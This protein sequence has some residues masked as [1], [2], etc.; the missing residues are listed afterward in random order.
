MPERAPDWFRSPEARFRTAA[1]WFWHRVPGHAEIDAA[2]AD[3]ARAG[4]GSVLV[5]GRLALD[6]ADWMS[7]PWR[8]A[9]AHACRRARAHGLGVEIYDEYNWISG[10]GGGRTVAGAEHLRERL[11]FWCSALAGG[12][13]AVEGIRFPFLDFLGPAGQDWLCEAGGPAWDEWE[14]VRAVAHPAAPGSPAQIRDVTARARLASTGPQGAEVTVC[15]AAGALAGQQVTVFLAARGAR[16]R[17]INYAMPEA[18]ERFAEEVCAPML[19]AAGGRAEAS[20]FDHPHAGFYTWEGQAG[21]AGNALLWDARLGH[22]LEALAPLGT[23]LLAL[24]GAAGP[25]TRRLRARAWEIYGTRLH[26][27]FFGTLSRWWAARGVAFSGHELLCHVGGY[28]LRDGLGGFD[29]RTM[30]GLDHFGIDAFRDTTT[31]DAADYAPQLSARMGDSVAR[32]SGRAR[33]SVEQYSTGRMTGI[34]GGAGHWGLTA[35]DLRAQML[36]HLLSGARRVVLHALWLDAGRADDPTPF[37][38]PRF[39]FPPGFNLQPWWEDAPDLL[40]E[41][42]RVSAFL[43]E[44]RPERPVALLYPLWTLRAAGAAEPA[45]CAAFGRW[46]EALDRAGAGWQVIDHRALAAAHVEGDTLV[47]PA[48][49]FRA[50]VLPGVEMLAGPQE[51]ALI[52]RFRAAGGVVTGSGPLPAGMLDPAPADLSAPDPAFPPAPDVA[53]PLA[54]GDVARPA[55]DVAAPSAPGDVARPAPGDAAPAPPG[56]GSPTPPEDMAPTIPGDAAPTV[57]GSVASPARCDEAPCTPGDAAPLAPGDALSPERG[58]AIPPVSGDAAT[59]LAGDAPAPAAAGRSV[60]DPESMATLSVVRPVSSR[61]TTPAAASIDRSTAAPGGP[62]APTPGG[63]S[64]PA[65]ADRPVPAPTGVPETATRE[66]PAPPM[67]D[68]QAPEALLRACRAAIARMDGPRDIAARAQDLAALARL[69]PGALA[70]C[71][72]RD[73]EGWKLALFNDSGSARDVQVAL[74]AGRWVLRAWTAR[75][76][77]VGPS[78]R[79]SGR[80]DL[81]LPPQACVCLRLD[82]DGM[83]GAE[84]AADGPPTAPGRSRILETRVLDAGWTLALAGAQAFH[85]VSVREGWER[86][87]WPD[88]SGT[89]LYRLWLDLPAPGPGRRW[90]LS[91]PG[92]RHSGTARFAGQDLG[93][94]IAG[95]ARFPLPPGRG[96]LELAL[97]NTGANRFYAGAPWQPEGPEASGLCQPPLLELH[98]I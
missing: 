31:V 40:A 63:T 90:E 10:H 77:G 47:T 22:A 66:M 20:F 81:H 93:R 61:T 88:V 76:G 83:P 56:D 2:L 7:A 75:D 71:V 89:G 70:N 48:G 35:E 84:Q 82:P 79:V 95:D 72:L 44:G 58:D 14:I 98:A 73:G 94:H 27:A 23:V 74:P 11:L 29:P 24:T 42:A 17:L 30:P 34:P 39:D 80:L 43:E 32:A 19:A 12:R 16:S 28:G 69:H 87:G 18:A 3:M 62:A 54:P 5:Q 4:I 67:G 50:L 97:R 15:D 36:R 26:E 53:A 1:F 78:R 37:L 85:P 59:P 21:A 86:Q 8:E 52:A 9:F 33:C 6:R 60:A 13:L 55:P 91:L 49:R 38:N 64:G 68:T 92:F 96:W 41:C 57:Q 51:A 65:P 46:A 25:D 45:C